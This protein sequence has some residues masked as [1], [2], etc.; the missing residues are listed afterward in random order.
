MGR[1][2]QCCLS[3]T[4]SSPLSDLTWRGAAEGRGGVNSRGLAWPGEMAWF[5]SKTQESAVGWEMQRGGM[6]KVQAQGSKQSCESLRGA[7][8]AVPSNGCVCTAKHESERIPRLS[9]S[10]L[11]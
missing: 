9:L 10:F 8:A 3:L 5:G 6:G 2:P 7:G 4:G 1:C 11:G